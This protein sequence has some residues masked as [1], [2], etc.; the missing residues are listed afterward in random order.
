MLYSLRRS[1]IKQ[2]IHFDFSYDPTSRVKI[3]FDTVGC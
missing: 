1:G 2:V 3:F